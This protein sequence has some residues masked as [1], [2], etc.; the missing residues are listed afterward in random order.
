MKVSTFRTFC[1]DQERR[2]KDAL[3]LVGRKVG[4]AKKREDID[5]EQNADDPMRRLYRRRETAGIP[6]LKARR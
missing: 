2:L 4:A 6:Y 5:I 3:E 1:K